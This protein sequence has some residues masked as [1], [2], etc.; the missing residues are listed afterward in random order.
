MQ[1][2]SWFTPQGSPTQQQQEVGHHNFLKGKNNF[3]RKK[4]A[5]AIVKII[6]PKDLD[7]EFAKIPT[8]FTEVRPEG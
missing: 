2:S 5:C 4:F 3:Y 8:T 1:D 7:G 6:A